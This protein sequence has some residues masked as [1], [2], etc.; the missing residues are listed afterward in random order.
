MGSSEMDTGR[1]RLWTLNFISVCLLNFAIYI[2]FYGLAPTLPIY[3]ETYGGSSAMSGLAMGA[4]SLAGIVARPVAGWALDKYGR[5]MIIVGGLLVYLLPAV[6]FIWMIPVL[7]LIILR[8][9]Q[10]LGWAVANTSAW[11]V[12]SDIVPP[13]RM[14]EG[15][16]I[17]GMT[18]SISMALSPALILWMEKQYSFESI[19][20]L[21]AILIAFALIISLFIKYPQIEKQIGG[22]KPVFIE[23]AVLRPA[24]TILFISLVNSAQLSFIALH[25]IQQ[26]LPSAG[27]YFTVFAVFTFV[28]RP[29]S[30]MIID[31]KG[32]KGF[33]MVVLASCI[34]MLISMSILA[35]VT[36]LFH[37][38]LGGVFFGLGAGSIQPTI[39]AECINMVPPSRRG[40]ANATYW[41]AMDVGMACGSIGWGVVASVLGYRSMFN[42]TLIPV[43]IAM[44]IYFTRRSPSKMQA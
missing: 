30:G 18:L 39:L 14:G 5:R 12:A 44:I 19:F 7:T 34:S 17:F 29:I 24:I 2:V 43:V 41:A 4:L 13:A 25:A 10:G 23:T 9:F 16:G 33:D 31:R 1:P 20:L 38:A 36:T 27:L 26:G 40:A 15:M 22:L 11:T 32:K 8:F 21:C 42:L 6:V 35:R 3:I 37:L 28:F